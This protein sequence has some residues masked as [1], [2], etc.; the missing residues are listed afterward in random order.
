MPSYGPSG[1]Q[2]IY[3]ITSGDPYIMLY[4]DGYIVLYKD[5]EEVQR[6]NPRFVI[7]IEW[8]VKG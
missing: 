1:E 7:S 4:K 6:I 8:E 2:N 3:S 5:G